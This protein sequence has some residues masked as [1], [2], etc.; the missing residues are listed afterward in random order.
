MIT[1]IGK[2]LLDIAGVYN[3]EEEDVATVC[4]RLKLDNIPLNYRP[5]VLMGL[6]L[7][8]MTLIQPPTD[9]ED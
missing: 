4:V 8:H 7:L 1:K 9:D 6:K 5:F 2:A 3:P